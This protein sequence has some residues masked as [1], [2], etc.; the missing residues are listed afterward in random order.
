[1]SHQLAQ[2]I[3]KQKAARLLKARKLSLLLDLDQTL[4]HATVDPSVQVWLDTLKEAPID[5]H[6]FTLPGIPNRHY[7]K[8]RPGTADF[9]EEM[10]KIYEMHIY[11]HGSRN[12]A[13]AVA[14]AIDPTKKYF[15]SRILSRDD[16]GCKTI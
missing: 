9:L 6:S 16:S 7:I 15:G 14:K 3:E 12:Y 5:I 10:N 8:L 2:D 11:T 4:V 1:M 13:E